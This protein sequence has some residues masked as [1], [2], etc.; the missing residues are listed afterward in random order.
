MRLDSFVGAFL[1]AASVAAQTPSPT[2]PTDPS[3]VLS[4]FYSTPPV[5]TGTALTS[6]ASA[7]VSVVESYQNAPQWQSMNVDI[8]S[9]APSS[10]QASML[11]GTWNFDDFTAAPWWTSVPSEARS[12][13]AAENSALDSVGYKYLGTPTSAMP[14]STSKAGAAQVTAMAGAAAAVVGLVGAVAAL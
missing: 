3:A 5:V 10:V 7:L 14:T 11:T 1:F 9:A 13:F 2:I 4:A 6:L 8:Y 12:F